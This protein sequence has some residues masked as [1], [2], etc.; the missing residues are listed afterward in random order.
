MIAIEQLIGMSLGYAKSVLERESVAYVVEKTE[1]K[2]RFFIC[3]PTLVYVIRVRRK[4][5]VVYLL[6]NESLKRS[7]SVRKAMERRYNS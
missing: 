6:V 4:A 1:S 2:S 3:D 7:D 5:N